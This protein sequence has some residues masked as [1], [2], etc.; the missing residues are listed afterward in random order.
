MLSGSTSLALTWCAMRQVNQELETAF[1]FNQYFLK[2]ATDNREKNLNVL[3]VYIFLY[4]G[5]S[6]F[7]D[8]YMNVQNN[9]LLTNLST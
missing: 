7:T 1:S 9:T 8:A 3:D 2:D 6:P 4:L 5:F